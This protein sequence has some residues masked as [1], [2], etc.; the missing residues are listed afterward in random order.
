MESPAALTRTALSPISGRNTAIRNTDAM[1][2]T[3]AL[4]KRV[5]FDVVDSPDCFSLKT[6]LYRATPFLSRLG[7]RTP[8][9]VI[10]PGESPQLC[11]HKRTASACNPED[12]VSPNK[13][14]KSRSVHSPRNKRLANDP[15]FTPSG[16]M[17]D[18]VTDVSACDESLTFTPSVKIRRN[19]PPQVRHRLSE[20]DH[21]VS[22]WYYSYP[23]RECH[24]SK[25][26]PLWSK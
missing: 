21:S 5:A 24:F 7:L 22:I 26:F 4:K 12:F 3:P 13:H 14:L 19:T 16:F 10:Y 8:S 17:S 18:A 1:T 9:G 25:A 15:P 23:V 6:P 20:V 11:K 2:S